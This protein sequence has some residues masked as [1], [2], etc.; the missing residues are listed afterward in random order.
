MKAILFI[1]LSGF[2]AYCEAQ[3]RRMSITVDDLPAVHYGLNNRAEITRGLLETFVKYEVPAIGYVNEG[4][5][6]KNGV[7]DEER[8]AYL[9]QWLKAGLELG[10]HSFSHMNYHNN[11]LKSF[12]EDV[13]KGEQIIKPLAEKYGTEIKYFRHPYLRSGATKETS[14]TLKEFL[15]SNGYIEAPV[16]IDNEEYLFAKAYAV[17][18]RKGNKELAKKVAESYLNYMTVQQEYYEK[19]SNDLLGRNMD[20]ILLIHANLLNAH[21]LDELLDIYK[22]KGYDFITQQEALKDPGYQLEVTRFDDWGISWIHRWG[23]SKGLKGDFFKGE[24]VTPEFVRSLS[25]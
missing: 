24:A 11:D 18:L 25:N 9:E 22:E 2:L 19:A 12:G 16:T 20:H 10:N 21:Y 14:N 23:L 8:V 13:L 4:K 17:A 5:L 7:L 3:N 6:Y 1:I 15:Q